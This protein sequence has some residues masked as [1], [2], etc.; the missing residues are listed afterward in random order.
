MRP[1]SPSPHLF[2][3]VSG[4]AFALPT[5]DV[6]ELV[7]PPRLW[8]PPTCPA[9]LAGILDLRGEAIPV[10][11]L[12]RLLGLAPAAGGPFAPIVVLRRR[13]GDWAVAAD[14]VLDVAPGLSSSP[15]DGAAF[16]GCVA[17]RLT[18][19]A[20]EAHLLAPERLLQRR[21]EAVLEEF[22]SLAAHRMDVEWRSG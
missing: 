16:H 14:A 5:P 1:D 13:G 12:D 17:A 4:E 15:V 6:R 21:E 7:L 20:G 3:R 18:W 19:A 10:L 11:R 22:R 9:A 2:F 8:R